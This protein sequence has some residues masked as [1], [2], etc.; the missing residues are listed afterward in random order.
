MNTIEITIWI[1]LIIPNISAY[2]CLTDQWP[3]K[4]KSNIPTYV[5]DLDTPPF[6]R[7][8]QIITL[9]KSQ[10]IRDVLDYTKHFI[11]NT[12]PVF[13][14][15]IDIMHTKLP[16]IADTLPEPYGQELKGISQASGISLGEIIFYNIFYE[17]S[18]LCTSIVTQDQNGYIIHGRNLDFGLLLGWDKVN[19]SWIL[20]N[21]L[22]PLV[23]AINYTKNGEIRFQ[24]ISFAGFIG[25]VT[26]IKPGKFSITL[27]TRFDLNGGY[28]GIIE[29]IYNINR[30]QSF[31][32][33]AI[34]DMLTGAENYDEAVEYLS[35]IPLLAPCY[36]ILAGIKSGQGIIIS[37]SRQTS[38]NIKT[39]DTNN[40]WYLIQTNYDNWRKQP[41]I[42][43]RLTPAIQCIET[44][45]KNNTNFESLFNLLS[46]QPMLNK[47]TIYTTLMKPSTG[48]LESYI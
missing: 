40:Q 21:K 42:D 25:A 41:S 34:R 44:Q 47:L 14:F 23:I 20:T 36:Y 26:G 4:S 43:D 8:N 39:L 31:V 33:L 16:L 32:T 18:S 46:S 9:Y 5:I 28:I 37:R 45:G 6:Q 12:W 10:V 35:K 13:T 11:V 7:R 30:N 38:V 19:K 1:L 22:R 15:L 24:T 48:Q 27:N 17:I 2:Q 3:P 29:W